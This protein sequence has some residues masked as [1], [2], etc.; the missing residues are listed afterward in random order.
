MKAFVLAGG[1]GTR[2]RPRFGELPKGLAPLAGRPFLAHTLDWL[3][4]G[5]VRDVVLCLG[6]GAEAIREALGDGSSFGVRI[7]YS[8]EDRPL[9]T[10]GALKLAARF[11]DGPTLVMNGDTLAAFDA[12]EL[13]RARWESGAA[14]AVALVH[15]EDAR[16]RGRVERDAEGWVTRFVEKDP[17][18]TGPAWVS[19]GLY[20]FARE[21]WDRLPAGESSLERDLL[22]AI[23][24][25]RRLF[26]CAIQGAFHDIGTPEGLERAERRLGA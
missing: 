9:G 25:E 4:H 17:D 8:I 24:R 14:A 18:H 5:A 6:V 19:G 3:A 7:T 21:V 1:L 11:V 13:E 10:G 2:L 20:A 26:G 23:A 12:W 16:A 22:P 15:V